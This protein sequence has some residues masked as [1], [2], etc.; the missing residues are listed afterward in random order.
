LRWYGTA[1]IL[2]TGGYKSLENF[3]GENIPF[4]KLDYC[5]I[6]AVFVF[7]VVSFYLFVRKRGINFQKIINRTFQRLKHGPI[8]CKTLI[9]NKQYP[10]NLKNNYSQYLLLFCKAD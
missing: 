2:Y 4:E 3:L 1:D 9:F 8:I 10:L 5:N 6:A 7:V